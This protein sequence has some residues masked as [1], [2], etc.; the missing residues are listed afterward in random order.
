VS[1][2]RAPVPHVEK[3]SAAA[4]ADQD[5]TRLAIGRRRAAAASENRYMHPATL[6]PPRAILVPTAM[7]CHRVQGGQCA[8]RPAP[9]RGVIFPRPVMTGERRQG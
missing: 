9:L 1:R 3:Q 2:R 8:E 5:A 4:L 6:Q 7:S